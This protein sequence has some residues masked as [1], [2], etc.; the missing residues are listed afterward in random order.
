[1]L[2]ALAVDLLVEPVL[3]VGFPVDELGLLKPQI[4]LLVGVLDRITSVAD[5][6]ANFDAEITTDG[7]RGRFKWV[8]GSEHLASSGDLK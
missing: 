7:T 1:M 6:S 8:G 2:H 5:V 3:G 4:Q